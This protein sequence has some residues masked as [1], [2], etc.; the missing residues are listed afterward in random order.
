MS[1]AIDKKED[2]LLNEYSSLQKFYEVQFN[3]FMGVFYLW[4]G[5]LGAGITASFL[6][7]LDL[8]VIQKSWTLGITLW[9]TALL[10]IFLSQKMFDIRMSQF[11]Y[12]GKLNEM[13]IFFWEKYKLN[14]ECLTPLSKNVNLS[15][16]A[17]TDFGKYMAYVMS[18]THGG[19]VFFGA[20][21]MP[22]SIYYKITIGIIIGI[23]VAIWNIRQYNRIVVRKLEQIEKNKS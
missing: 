15:Q 5:V 23:I 12:I 1:E 19:L 14:E 17:K 3:H 6:S 16:I 13:R 10:G 18:G 21:S 4:A 20:L 7:N 9:I 22:C 2:F 8:S 11:R